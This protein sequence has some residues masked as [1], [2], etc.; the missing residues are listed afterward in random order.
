MP[1]FN[2]SQ[3]KHEE[4]LTCIDAM[5]DIIG[6]YSEAVPIKFLGDFNA[7]LLRSAVTSNN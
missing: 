5:R 3:D 1:Y 6:E 7:H 2:G 4:F